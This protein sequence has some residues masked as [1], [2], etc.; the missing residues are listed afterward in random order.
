MVLQV[1][2]IGIAMHEEINRFALLADVL[3]N[4]PT[5]YWNYIK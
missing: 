3:F 5:Q 2:L 1:N 4:R